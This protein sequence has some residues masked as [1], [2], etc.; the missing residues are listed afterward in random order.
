VSR[1]SREQFRRGV[2]TSGASEQ[3]WLLTRHASAHS[4]GEVL[5][6]LGAAV[7]DL[8]RNSWRL[9][10]ANSC[11]ALAVLVP[12]WVAVELAVPAPLL[13][14][15]LAGPAC[16]GLAYCAVSI[17]DDEAG[18]GAGEIRIATFG[19][20]VRLRWRRGLALGALFGLVLLAGVS[21]VRFYAERGGV[22]LLAAFGCGYLLA[23]AVLFQLVLWPVAA[24]GAER[25]LASAAEV[26]LR[27][28]PAVLRLGAVLLVVNV[29][30]ALII[31]PLLTFTIAYSF[32]ASARLLAPATVPS[33]GVSW[34]A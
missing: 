8:Y 7:R 11:V 28:W 10:V 16:A 6:A 34:P 33:G 2:S 1:V 5:T 4:R 32:L 25:P 23:A 14:A 3:L 18:G 30:G 21:A 19:R 27:C 20:G 13:L 24:R 22:W 9:V 17:V 15:L 31:L 26:F 12:A 29:V